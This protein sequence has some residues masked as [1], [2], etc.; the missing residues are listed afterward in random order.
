MPSRVNFIDHVI[1]YAKAG[2]GGVGSRHL[3]RERSNPKGGP[4]GGDGGRGGHI[5]L[6]GDRQL[7]TLEHLRYRKHAH[8]EPGT[9][10]M[11]NNRHGKNGMDLLLPVPLGTVATQR[12]TGSVLG[13]ILQDKEKKM[14]L[15]GGRGGLGNVHFK[16]PTRRTPRITSDPGVTEEIRFVLE[17]QLL[18]DV[19]LVGQPN[20]GKSSLLAALSRSRSVV[21]PYPFSTLVPALGVVSCENFRTFVLADLPGII[22][23]AS[24][25][26]GLGLRFLKHIRRNKMLSFVVPAD[27][28]RYLETYRSLEAEVGNFAPEIL[29]KPK[30]LII[31][32]VDLGVNIQELKRIRDHVT[33]ANCF[34][35]SS[36]TR[37]GLD[38][39]KEAVASALTEV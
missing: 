39:F 5:Y 25:G 12:D 11:S 13:E 29:K 32:K 8:A 19:G 14:I 23:G 15:Q 24:Q 10:G 1:L 16:S 7:T 17:L 4:D 27:Q 3:R 30:I 38:N 6:V 22:G 9:R 2:E 20:A 36:V 18:A 21:A 28:D 37:E 34:L 31:S 35:T 33:S 26:K